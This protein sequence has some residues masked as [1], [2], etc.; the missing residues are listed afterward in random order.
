MLVLPHLIYSFNI[1][2]I[3]SS[4]SYNVDVNKLILKLMWKDKRF[5]IAYTVLMRKNKLRRLTL[6][7]FRASYAAIIR[8]IVWQRIDNS[9]EQNSGQR[10]F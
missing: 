7:N 5:K 6:L 8:N 2:T 10:D 9:M 3:K 4:E 1:I